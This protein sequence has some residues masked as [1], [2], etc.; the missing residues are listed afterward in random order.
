MIRV[1]IEE[2]QGRLPLLLFLLGR[3]SKTHHAEIVI[4]DDVLAGP[5]PKKGIEIRDLSAGDDALRQVGQEATARVRLL[6]QSPLDGIAG[7][8]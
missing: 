2:W 7:C 5:F 8:D 3:E 6:D 1:G 4:G